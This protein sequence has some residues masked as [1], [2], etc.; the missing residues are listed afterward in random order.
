M[1]NKLKYKRVGVEAKRKTK[2]A[3]INC[4]CLPEVVGSQ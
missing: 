1:N 3:A 4:R 2:E